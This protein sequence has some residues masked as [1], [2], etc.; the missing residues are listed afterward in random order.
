[1][2]YILGFFAAD[3][4]MLKNRRG[5]YFVEFTNIDRDLLQKIKKLICPEHK[6]SVRKRGENCKTSY[7]IQIGS[8]K[9]YR[10][11]VMLGFGKRKSKRLKLPQMPLEYFNHFVRGYFDG[12]GSV[13]VTKYKR[14]DRKD[15]NYITILAGFT[16]GCG[17]FLKELHELFKRHSIIN[18]GT[19]C[20]SQGY[21]LY[22]SVND[23]LRLYNFMYKNCGDL[24]LIRKK[25][26]FEKYFKIN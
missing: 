3:G 4:N 21:R 11:L 23:S 12:D 20:Y 26:I 18:G 14:A 19:F 24:F 2:A 16:S 8:K 1:M 7:R 9:V 10:D 25:K 17:K 13:V 22:F 6:I 15:K 5:A